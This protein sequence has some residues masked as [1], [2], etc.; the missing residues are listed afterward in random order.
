MAPLRAASPLRQLDIT[1]VLQGPLGFCGVFERGRFLG[2]L[3]KGLGPAPV[4]V[5]R[6]QNGPG[7][8]LAC[9]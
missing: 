5:S 3:A 7:G 8:S 2:I 4:F 9:T 1:P 6:A